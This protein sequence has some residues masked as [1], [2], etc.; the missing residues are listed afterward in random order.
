MNLSEQYDHVF[1]SAIK[2]AVEASGLSCERVDQYGRPQNVPYAI[3]QEIVKADLV[4][5]DVSVP[6]PNVFYELGISHSV[7]NKTIIIADDAKNLPFDV[8]SE[9]TLIYSHDQRGLQLLRFQLKEYIDDLLANPTRPSNIVQIAGQEY[10]DLRSKVQEQLN[11]LVIQSN[12][13]AAF[14]EYLAAGHQTDNSGV[15]GDLAEMI[16]ERHSTTRHTTFVAISGAAGLGKTTLGNEI[17]AALSARANALSIGLLQADAYMLPRSERILRD[18]SG[19]DP[20]ANDID[21]MIK[22]LDTLDEGGSISYLPYDHTTGTHKVDRV[23]LPRSDIVLVDGI[24]SFHPRA[25]R[26]MKLKLFLYATPAD[27]KELRFMVDLFERSYT[28]HT[29]FQHAE[30]EYSSFETHI[31]HYV[32]FADHVVQIDNYW[33]YHL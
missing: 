31:L 14:Q 11:N 12:R 3:V 18:L 17:K 33:K 13:T 2:P 24:H 30:Q 26:R 1:S 28:A 4:I 16:L 19:Y 9:S 29:A 23:S 32:K 21:A 8:R 20:K 25:L 27:G 15:V 6:S 5:A 7:G 22:D 10:F